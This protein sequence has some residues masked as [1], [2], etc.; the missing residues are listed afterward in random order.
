MKRV[1]VLAPNWLGDV[2]MALPAMAAVRQWFADAHLA[3]AARPS[4]APVLSM[5]DGLDGV[6]TLTGRDD[7][8][9]LAAGRFDA[10]LLL[11]NSFAAAW[12][13]RQAGGCASSAGARCSSPH[14][15]VAVLKRLRV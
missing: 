12:L 13:A 14:Y 11:P 3:V 5:A 10:A 9:D 4:V 2:V 8:R 1:V 6:I 15:R 7:A